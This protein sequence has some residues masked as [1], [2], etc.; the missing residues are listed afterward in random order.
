MGQLLM[1]YS[2]LVLGTNTAQY[3]PSTPETRNQFLLTTAIIIGL[4]AHVVWRQISSLRGFGYQK[5]CMAFGT[6][7]LLVM[8]IALFL[9]ECGHWCAI[10]WK[11]NQKIECANHA[12]QYDRNILEALHNDLTTVVNM[13]YLKP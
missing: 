8:E 1:H 7:G 12:L 4:V 11:R 2:L 10:I 6:F 13:S 3:V 5:R 9:S